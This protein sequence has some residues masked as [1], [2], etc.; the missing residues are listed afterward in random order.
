MPI[1]FVIIGCIFA[2][3]IIYGFMLFLKGKQTASIDKLDEQKIAIFDIP[4]DSVILK[5]KT[6]HLSGKTK[7]LYESWA[8]QWDELNRDVLPTVEA[9]LD[10]AE[11]YSN[12]LKFLKSKK[13]IDD[14]KEL[15]NKS[16]KKAFQIDEAL[17]RIVE[18]EHSNHE[19]IETVRNQYEL[20]KQTVTENKAVYKQ[21]IVALEEKISEIALKFETFETLMEDADFL[22]AKE[23]L[24]QAKAEALYLEKI[25][26]D[27]PTLH[28]E[29]DNDITEQLDDLKQGYHQLNEESYQ[30]KDVNLLELLTQ[31]EQSIANTK[32]KVILLQIEHAKEDKQHVLEQI[33][34][35][36]TVMET[37]IN[38]KTAVLKLL[39]KLDIK[40]AQILENNKFLSIEIERLSENYELTDNETEDIIDFKAI[41]NEFAVKIAQY[42]DD[43]AQKS[44][45]FSELKHDLAAINEKLSEL[46]EKQTIIKDNLGSLKQRENDVKEQLDLFE[47][48]LRNMKRQLEKQHLPGLSPVYLDL[49]MAC[50]KQ[51]EKLSALLNKLKINM[52][53]IDELVELCT[54]DI[55]HLEDATHRIIENALM[56]E[57][58]VQYA[59]RYRSEYA[60][61]EKAITTAI[62]LY[63]YQYK[64]T[65]ARQTMEKSLDAV[66]SGASKRVFD[67]FLL[68]KYR[69]M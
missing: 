1:S 23:V 40:N 24:E 7:K 52:K 66:E 4:V 19:A 15:L 56:T 42:T 38:A 49:F 3:I 62:N 36:Y 37:E 47:L 25:L 28:H 21:S 63:Q 18:S 26:V 68:D 30:F 31:L 2:I 64:Y 10:L 32:E 11:K 35:L 60:S 65:E 61:I 45:V 13:M 58:L 9:E 17:Q 6:M 29:I 59:N 53:E 14:I 16:E 44:V 5:L 55:E 69:K 54:T 48:D 50:T 20:V 39:P 67:L 43:V 34:Y 51:V 46:D 8:I 22:E 12:Q 41:L 57:Q 27:I 33:D